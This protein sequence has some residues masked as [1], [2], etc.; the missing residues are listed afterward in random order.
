LQWYCNDK[1]ILENRH[2][3]VE[4]EQPHK[5]SLVITNVQ[6]SDIGRYAV[7]AHNA[8]GEVRTNCSLSMGQPHEEEPPKFTAAD[9]KQLTGDEKKSSAKK[10]SKAVNYDEPHDM[11]RV[12]VHIQKKGTAPAFIV[13]LE[14]IE[15]NA[16]DTAAVAGK[17]AKS[18]C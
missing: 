15:L 13:G 6:V 3:K 14:D 16:G 2:F 10:S 7:E 4:Y 18:E 17:L 9:P 12:R 11:R 1:R 8:H 5:C